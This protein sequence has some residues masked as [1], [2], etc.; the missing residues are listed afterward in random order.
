MK[1]WKSRKRLCDLCDTIHDKSDNN[2]EFT[3]RSKH[4]P[5]AHKTIDQ[6]CSEHISVSKSA[7]HDPLIL[8]VI[9]TCAD[10]FMTY[11]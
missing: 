7:T 4:T 3:Y 1:F 2:P 9:N 11:L 10:V 6:G 5:H 8:H